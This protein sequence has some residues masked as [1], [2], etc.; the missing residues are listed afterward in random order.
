MV[1]WAC[2]DFGLVRRHP[3]ISSFTLANIT[4][5]QVLALFLVGIG[6]YLVVWLGT[7]WELEVQRGV[8]RN[9]EEAKRL[10][11]HLESE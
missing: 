8:E 1:V 7:D 4:Q 3:L 9:Q 5:G 2:K 10:V 6:E 11:V